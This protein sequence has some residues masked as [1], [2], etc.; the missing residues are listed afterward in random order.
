[1]L[2]I[3][4]HPSP[5]KSTMLQDL[6]RFVHWM[7]TRLGVVFVVGAGLVWYLADNPNDGM[8]GAIGGIWAICQVSA[9]LIK[10]AFEL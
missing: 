9:G 8:L 3:T 5:G 1:M 10:W 7:L 6:P 4:T 2:G